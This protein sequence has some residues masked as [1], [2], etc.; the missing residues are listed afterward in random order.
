LV[1]VIIR[2]SNAYA[3]DITP[4]AGTGWLYCAGANSD[5]EFEGSKEVAFGFDNAFAYQVH[6]DRVSC[7][8][9]VFGDPLPSV[10]KYCWSRAV[11]IE[12]SVT[13]D[14]ADPQQ[15]TLALAGLIIRKKQRAV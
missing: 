13:I 1:G 6:T 8:T 5:C 2:G 10:N 14:L 15:K 7:A 3:V 4:P 11:D 12:N 9:S